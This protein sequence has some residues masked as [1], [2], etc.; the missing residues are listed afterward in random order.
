MFSFTFIFWDNIPN[1]LALICK[2]KNTHH[3]LKSSTNLAF[4]FIKFCLAHPEI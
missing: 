4:G 3:T 2:M 1:D